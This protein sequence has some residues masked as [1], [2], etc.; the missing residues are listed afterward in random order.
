MRNISAQHKVAFY[1]SYFQA[2]HGF[3]NFLIFVESFLFV[4]RVLLTATSHGPFSLYSLEKA[5]LNLNQE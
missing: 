4:I 1:M 3:V 2:L 5:T